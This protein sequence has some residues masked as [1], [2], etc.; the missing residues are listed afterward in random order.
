M[1]EQE[2]QKEERRNLR[3]KNKENQSSNATE[4]KPDTN[5]E[6]KETKKM[7]T[8]LV[9]ITSLQQFEKEIAEGE[10]FVYFATDSCGMCS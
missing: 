4:T 9:K 6:Q 8:P 10:V 2:E 1:E 5:S 3:R 7:A